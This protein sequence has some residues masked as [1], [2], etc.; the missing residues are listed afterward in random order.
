MVYEKELEI[1]YEALRSEFG[2]E[3]E[4]LGNFQISLQRLYAARRTD[5]D[6][7]IL[8]IS[9]S[10]LSQTHI[11]IVKTDRPAPQQGELKENPKGDGDLYTLADLLGDD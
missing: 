1:L 8:Q 7:D 2:I 4:L 5:P 3:I 6:L 9:R 11:W 10:P